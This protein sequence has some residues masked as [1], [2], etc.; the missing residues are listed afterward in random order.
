MATRFEWVLEGATAS[1]VRAA[2]EEAFAEVHRIEAALSVYRPDSQISAVNHGAAQSAVRV[3]PEVY[4]LIRRACDLSRVTDG[5][6]DITVGPLLKAW[7]MMDKSGRQPE[8]RE[9]MAARKCVGWDLLE[10]D[11]ADWRIRFRRPGVMLD[12]GSIGKGY[13]LDRAVEILREA[14]ITAAFLHGGTS[15]AIAIGRPSEGPAW[16]IAIEAPVRPGDP[17]GE[18]RDPVAVVELEDESLSVSA[19]WGKGYERD[20]RFYGHVMDPSAGEPVAGA[21]MAA[22]ILPSA[23]ESDALSTALLVRGK[24]L[25]EK[26]SMPEVN[27]RCLVLEKDESSRGYSVVTNGISRV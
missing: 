12:L 27:I 20:G 13:A 14:G 15:T 2:G 6:F 21:L 11:P 10:L 18:P 4:E 8:P 16:K 19:I 22:V 7:G 1:S 17:P 25:L 3:T 26:L 5:A 9:L 23:T 24:T